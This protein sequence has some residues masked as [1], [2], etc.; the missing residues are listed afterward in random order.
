MALSDL[1]GRVLY[2]LLP[3][4][5][6]VSK[7]AIDTY[8]RWRAA[9]DELCP[10]IIDHPDGSWHLEQRRWERELLIR[11]G[12]HRKSVMTASREPYEPLDCNYA[13]PEQPA[14]SRPTYRDAR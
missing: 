3:A 14:F 10:K 2:H 9:N 1:W 8:R 4:T 7:M 6:D 11:M 13:T 12:L 5:G